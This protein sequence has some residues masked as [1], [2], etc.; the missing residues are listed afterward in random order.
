LLVS[1]LTL[2][3]FLF[4]AY[5][6]FPPFAALTFISAFG[7]INQMA[8]AVNLFFL[9]KHVVVPPCKKLIENI[10]QYMGFNIAGRYFSK[11]P[12]TL[13]EDRYIIDQLLMKT[14]GYDSFSPK[15]NQQEL[16]RFNKL[17]TKLSEYIDKYDESI[18]GY[19]NN[20]DAITDLERQIAQLTTRGNIDSSYAFIQRKIGFKTTKIQMLEAAKETVSTALNNSQN[21]LS[22][23]LSYFDAIDYEDL[24]ENQKKVLSIGLECLQNEIQRQR[25]KIVSLQDCLPIVSLI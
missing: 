6:L 23:A 1:S 18:L 10:A 9:I 21:D 24:E 12:L 14:Y 25:T 5:F 13:E 19:I 16:I 20:K 17:L 22:Q 8:L 2:A 3:I 15:Y 7:F 11:P 4:V